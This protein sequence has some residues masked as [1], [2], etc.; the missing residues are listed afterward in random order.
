M[1][2]TVALPVSLGV[3]A[4]TMIAVLVRAYGPRHGLWLASLGS[5]PLREALSF[6]IVGTVSVYP[7]DFLYLI[8]AVDL[9]YSRGYSEVWRNSTYLKLGLALILLSLPGFYTATKVFWGITS[10]Y[11]D[12]LQLLVFFI[13]FMLIRD[14]SD[15]RRA[16]LALVIGLVPALVYGIFQST[17][18]FDAALPDWANR[19][20]AY[21]ADGRKNIRIFSTFDHPIRFSHY[22][23]VSLAIALGLVPGSKHILKLALAAIACGIV[24][25]NFQTFSIGGLLGMIAAIGTLAV[26]YRG[27]LALAAIPIALVLFL[28]V[29]PGALTTK[30]ERVL[31]GKATTVA[32]RVVTYQQA[33]SVLKDHPFLGLGW[34]GIRT[35]LE[36]EYRLTRASTVAFAAENY[37]LQYGIAL[38]LPGIGI[39]VTI[40][41][42]FM[43]QIRRIPRNWPLF[44]I[45]A[46]GITW[47][48]Q[49]QFFPSVS[50]TDSFLLWALLAVSER[51][52][53]AET[54]VPEAADA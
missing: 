34:G 17:L 48:L 51:A 28:I 11:R 16:L 23:S 33:V 54:T 26:L 30:A 46:A 6:D 13:T 22:L 52:S 21:D 47:Y 5:I 8:L 39:V 15:A 36:G 19:M 44:A 45:T 25:C 32:A 14:A 53:R 31:T 3:L 29:S 24:Y 38:G 10:L 35:G 1:N 2:T 12:V 18:P 43:K 37:F 20:I 40:F 9:L 41:V 4:I 7:T 50:V 27:G 42:L 49:A